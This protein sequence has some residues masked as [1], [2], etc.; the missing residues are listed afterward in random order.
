MDFR[1]TV[2]FFLLRWC[3]LARF[4]SKFTAAS[5]GSP[6][7]STVFLFHLLTSSHLHIFWRSTPVTPEFEVSA[8]WHINSF[9]AR[10]KGRV[11]VL[12][13]NCV[14]MKTAFS[15]IIQVV[16]RCANFRRKYGGMRGFI[17]CPNETN[18]SRKPPIDESGLLP[19]LHETSGYGNILA[20]I[21]QLK[22]Y[23]FLANCLLRYTSNLYNDF[24]LYMNYRMSL[25]VFNES[26]SFV[27]CYLKSISWVLKA[28]YS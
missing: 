19:Q 27:R 20:K 7:D 24:S 23:T 11:S 14:R 16:C 22:R 4:V 6:C 8:M 1:C 21:R 13:P 18:Q 25:F 5:R 3:C 2:R 26:W 28:F 17:F 10:L 9:L 12:G 15:F